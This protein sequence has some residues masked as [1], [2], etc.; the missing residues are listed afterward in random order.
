MNKNVKPILKHNQERI[1]NF[2]KLF[3][4]E[5]NMKKKLLRAFTLFYYVDICVLELLEIKHE[6]IHES[7]KTKKLKIYNPE[8]EKTDYLDLS[9]D[10]IKELKKLFPEGDEREVRSVIKHENV[11]DFT[12]LLN[13]FIQASNSGDDSFCLASYSVG[14][15]ERRKE[16]QNTI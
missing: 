2:I 11:K 13:K 16:Q 8:S 14:I 12:F 7:F 15:E 4:R 1:I 10:A 5:N 9:A 3:I 6:D